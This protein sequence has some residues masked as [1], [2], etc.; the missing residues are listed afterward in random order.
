M[1][2][3]FLL[4]MSPLV[5]VPAPAAELPRTAL[6]VIE[7]NDNRQPAGTRNGSV[8]TLQLEARTG[9]WYPE[10]PTGRGLE[11]AAFGEPGK[12]LQ[13]PGPMIRVPAGTEI[14]IGLRNSLERPLTV[15]GL[16]KSRGKTDSLM[17]NAG[18][19]STATFLASTPGIYYY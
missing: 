11:V 1:L 17:V 16:G 4:V 14:R 10:G 2:P 6:P 5:A 13:N 18:G 15:F 3:L 8:L 19:S 12:P 7:A 9:L